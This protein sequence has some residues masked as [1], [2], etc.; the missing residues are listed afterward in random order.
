MRGRIKE[1]GEKKQKEIAME[2]SEGWKTYDNLDVGVD[3]PEGGKDL[4]VG[5][6]DLSGSLAHVDVVGA[7]HEVDDIGDGGFGPALN[8]LVGDVNRLPARVTL[9][10]G[11]ESGGGGLAV[12]GV[13]GHGANKVDLVGDTLSGEHVPDD[14]T[15]AG[16]LGDG[17]TERNYNELLAEVES[18]PT[19]EPPQIHIL[20]LLCTRTYTTHSLAHI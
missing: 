10:A 20:R 11:I 6:N 7:E 5:G 3:S 1:G 19:T 18:I 14:G 2:R 16:D 12:L 4:V 15:P 8:V 13:V 9:V 17:V